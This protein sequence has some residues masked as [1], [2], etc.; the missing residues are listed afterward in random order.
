MVQIQWQN[1][2]TLLV[3][4]FPLP[5]HYADWDHVLL[6]IDP[7]GK[8]DVVCDA[9]ELSAL[10]AD[11]YDAIYCSHN[12]EHYYKHDGAKVLR[13]FLHV[14]KPDGFAEILVPDINSVMKRAVES[15]LDLEDVLYDSPSGPMTVCDVVYG[16]APQI[17]RSGVDFYAHKTGFTA[18]SLQAVL[19]RSGFVNVYMFVWEEA[20][21]IKAIA[22]KREPTIAQRRL[23]AP[24]ALV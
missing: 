1:L 19:L 10:P 13:G 18:R 2:V 5:L 22:F 20:F 14:L 7:Q 23:L 6:D 11:Q 9:R 4:D 15:Q 3:D 16:W 24:L 8:P 12:L 21:E 17:E